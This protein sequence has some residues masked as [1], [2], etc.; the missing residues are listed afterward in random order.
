MRFGR[1]IAGALISL[2]S[3]GVAGAAPIDPLP[4]GNSPLGY[5]CLRYRWVDGNGN[6]AVSSRVASRGPS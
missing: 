6:P 2:A 5:D 3:V 4:D 1:W